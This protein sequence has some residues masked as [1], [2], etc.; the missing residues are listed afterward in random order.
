MTTDPLAFEFFNEIGIIDQL[1]SAML[2]NVLPKGMTKAQFTVLNHFV[3]L[4]IAEKSPAD[5]ASAFQV[6]RPTITSTLARMESAGLIAV[7]ADPQDG[8]A[9]LV[10]LTLAGREMRENCIA[11]LAS[12]IPLIEPVIGEAE[13]L[14][15]LPMLRNLRIGLDALRE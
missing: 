13:M 6:R 9:K 2:T 4:E 7:R 10:S 11:A 14:A 1:V 5:L 12:M 8:R 3:R 15:L